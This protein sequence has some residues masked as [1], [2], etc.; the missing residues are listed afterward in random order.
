[1]VVSP[2]VLL[3]VKPLCESLRDAWSLP[4]QVED[5]CLAP[6]PFSILRGTSSKNPDVSKILSPSKL[7]RREL[8]VRNSHL[9]HWALSDRQGKILGIRDHVGQSNH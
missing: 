2:K 9:T 4:N 7:Q 6:R 5:N 8:S 1:M 3:P